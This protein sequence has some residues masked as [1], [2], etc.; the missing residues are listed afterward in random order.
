MDLIKQAQSA[1]LFPEFWE[2][3]K[4]LVAKLADYSELLPE[5]SVR[6]WITIAATWALVI[7]AAVV[8]TLV[9][10]GS[11]ATASLE[12]AFR[13]L[14]PAV[15]AVLAA[16]A[17]AYTLL[18]V[19][20]S[21]LRTPE[22]LAAQQQITMLGGRVS[23]LFRAYKS[24]IIVISQ[25]L[26]KH[27]ET[28]VRIRNEQL[29]AVQDEIDGLFESHRPD[30]M[31]AKR[32][33][34][35]K[36][37]V[38]RESD[39]TIED[40]VGGSNNALAALGEAIDSYDVGKGGSPR[41]S[42]RQPATA[43]LQRRMKALEKSLDMECRTE[44]RI[45]KVALQTNRQRLTSA[46]EEQLEGSSATDLITEAERLTRTNILDPVDQLLEHLQA[47][48]DILLDTA[49]SRGADRPES[50]TVRIAAVTRQ[51]IETRRNR[52]RQYILA[53]VLGGWVPLA[54]SAVILA[55]VAMLYAMP[56]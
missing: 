16:L 39:Y 7:A 54:A 31:Q 4:H 25:I 11:A 18:T 21:E 3:E 28:C 37:K 2:E 27:L 17:T 52:R 51:L 42:R 36:T 33:Q 45:L 19:R 20:L 14:V 44:L 24:A 8:A 10:S 55:L 15:L 30:A 12:P 46:L 56:A 41:Q 40:F 43:A 49:Y 32:N 22:V 23:A 13:P 47:A 5:P 53:R 9:L 50:W 1:C 38:P 29:Q 34:R 6:D 26:F 48:Q 35:T